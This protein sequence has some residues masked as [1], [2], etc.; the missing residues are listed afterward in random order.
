MIHA[1]IATIATAIS[2]SRRQKPTASASSH[3]EEIAST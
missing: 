1:T 2:A 3:I